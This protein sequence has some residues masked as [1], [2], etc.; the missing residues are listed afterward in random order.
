MNRKTVSGTM[1]IVLLTGM[2]MLAFNIQSAEASGTIYIRPDGSVEGTDR[3]QRNGDIYTF[4]DNLYDSIVVERDNI[5]V[6]G[7]S[8]TLQ[9]ARSGT[10]IDLT[11][12][13]NVTIKNLQIQSFEYGIWHRI[14]SNNNIFGNNIRLNEYM[15]IIFLGGSSNNIIS[16]NNITANNNEGIFLGAASNNVIFGN[17]IA[18]NELP[19]IYLYH[20]WDNNVSGNKMANNGD[21]IWLGYSSSNI[22]FEN[23]ITANNGYGVM[24]Y[25]SF[26]NIISRNEIEFNGLGIYLRDSSNNNIIHH[27][28]FVHNIQQVSSIA[29]ANLWD[30]DYP[31]GGNY[32]SDHIKV[33]NYS[34]VNQDELGSDGIIDEPYIIDANNRDNYPLAIPIGT[35][36]ATIDI[37][38]ETLNIYSLFGRFVKAYIELPEGYDVSDIDIS[39]VKLNG[40]VQAELHPTK[41]GDYDRDGIP[42][43]MVKFDRTNVVRSILRSG[44]N[45]LIITG[46]LVEKPFMGRDTIRVRG[47]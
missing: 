44:E 27:N 12:R 46:K 13:S 14:G 16:G 15:G 10:G 31:S 19:G 38:P 40:E 21:G 35:V 3:I 4:T 7:A 34:G 26:D 30:D 24:F 37:F 25:G 39:T 29:S 28:N 36:P 32:W 47:G 42:D 18:N 20:S 23:D 17:N 2:L 41:I 5:A 43:L 8:Y 6:D 33:D 22:I 1:L 11:G 9:G 45:T